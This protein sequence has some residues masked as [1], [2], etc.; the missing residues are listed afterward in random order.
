MLYKDLFIYFA[1]FNDI[2]EMNKLWKL[3]KIVKQYFDNP[4]AKKVFKNAIDIKYNESVNDN[5]C[6]CIVNK[7]YF[8]VDYFIDKGANDWNGAMKQAAGNNY[9]GLVKYFIRKGANDLNRAMRCAAM[10]NHLNM[11]KFLIDKGANK[12]N[13]EMIQLMI[14]KGANKF[15]FFG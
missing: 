13:L 6:N 10:K 12:N 1:Q 2:S 5:L 3:N 11:V 9:F 4:H 8:L 7:D 15:L 14:D